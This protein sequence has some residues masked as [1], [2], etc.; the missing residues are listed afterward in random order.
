M[1]SYHSQSLVH[2]V[3]LVLQKDAF[4]NTDFCR[5]TYELKKIGTACFERFCKFQ[6]TKEWVNK[7]NLTSFELE[8]FFKFL[9]A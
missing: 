7:V 8:N 6:P 4:Q 9:L 1:N 5:L 3:D 2:E